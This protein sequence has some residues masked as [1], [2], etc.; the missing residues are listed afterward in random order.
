MDSILFKNRIVFLQ[1]YSL[2]TILFVLLGD[3]A[4]SA[5]FSTVFVFGTFQDHLNTIAFLCH[6]L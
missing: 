2:R 5:G 3:I 4:A 6:F 1:F